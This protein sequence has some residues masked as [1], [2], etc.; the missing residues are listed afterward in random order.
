[1]PRIG[2]HAQSK[3]A[4][5]EQGTTVMRPRGASTPSTGTRSLRS[6]LRVGL[7][8]VSAVF[9][10]VALKARRAVRSTRHRLAADSQRASSEPPASV[11]GPPF[12]F[13]GPARAQSEVLNIGAADSMSYRDALPASVEGSVIRP[14]RACAGVPTVR[15]EGILTPKLNQACGRARCDKCI[16]VGATVL[17]PD[18]PISRLP[19]GCEGFHVVGLGRP[20]AWTSVCPERTDGLEWPDIAASS[21]RPPLVVFEPVPFDPD[22]RPE[23]GYHFPRLPDSVQLCSSTTYRTGLYYR[24]DWTSEKR[25]LHKL[26]ALHAGMHPALQPPAD[27]ATGFP[28]VLR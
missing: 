25:S 3:A 12:S 11:R 26:Y 14:H 19:A 2:A 5:S 18:Q 4:L 24:Y 8:S 13:I 22:I 1:M 28:A 15:D 9:Q 6:S 21:T 27:P 17:N 7:S 16:S 10:N 23:D 20:G